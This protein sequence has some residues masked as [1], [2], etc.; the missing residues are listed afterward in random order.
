MRWL[1]LVLCA[2]PFSAAPAWCDQEQHQHSMTEEEV[3]SVHFANSCAKTEAASF[4]RSVAL[5]HSF[6][7]EH[8]RAAFTEIATRDSKCAMAQ[9]GIA[10]SHYH[11]LWAN[12]DMAAGRAALQKAQ[13]IAGA[14]PQTTAREKAYID[15]LG[16]IYRED[17]KDKYAHAQAFEEKMGALQAAYPDDVDA[18]IFHALMLDVT[19]PKAD[20]TFANQRKCGE[21][22]EP[23]LAKQPHNPGIAHYLIHCY[24]NPVLAEQGLNA[25]RMYAKIAPASAHANHMPSHIFT[26]VGSWYESIASN[27]KSAELAA[28]DERTSTNGEARDQ[29]LHAMDY[30]EYAYLQSGRVKQAKAVLDEMTS[31]PPL[32]GLTLTG[33]YA[34]AAIPARY[35][36]ELGKWQDAAQLQPLQDGVPWAQAI[37]WI[38]IGMGSARSENLE[39]ANQA[40]QTLAS[41]RDAATKLNNTY[42]A[43]QIE[44]QRREVLAWIAE[45]KGKTDDALAMMRSAAGLEE[46]MD[47]DAVTPGAVTPARE[48]LAELLLIEK[49][50][51]NALGEYEAVLKVAPNRFNALY[52][53]ATAADAAGNASAASQYFQKLTEI[54]VGDERPEL[55]TARKKLVAT[56]ETV[57]H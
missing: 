17:G 49:Q 46:S 3:G 26:R 40:V 51:Q 9:W 21:I 45:K 25:A 8:A 18:A 30:L 1:M 56:T 41:L 14:N 33:N 54:A 12:G 24:D 35:A 53:A 32:S 36:V 7:Y 39:R 31:L 44:V 37:S 15:A 2:L 4:N 52:G 16:E 38:A 19:A 5:L 13:E 29:R 55:V 10:M 22:L 11:G 20:K 50:P 6:Q 34:L 28:Q 47:K 57:I 27:M 43:N 48:M 42:W 23:L